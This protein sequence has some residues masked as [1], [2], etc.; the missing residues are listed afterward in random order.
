MLVTSLHEIACN[1]IVDFAASDSVKDI[2]VIHTG[3]LFRSHIAPKVRGGIFSVA[4]SPRT[5][6]DITSC[7]LVFSIS[8][9]LQHKLTSCSVS[10]LMRSLVFSP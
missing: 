1:Q 4:L 5:Y 8:R 7:G 3:T 10:I 9:R 6:G 2:D